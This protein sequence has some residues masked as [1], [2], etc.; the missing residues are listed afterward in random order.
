MKKNGH[1][2]GGF[3]LVEIMIVV[4]IIGLLCAIALPSFVRARATSQQNAC[5]NNL[6][7]IDSAVEQWAMETGQAAGNPPPGLT[8]DLTP[9]IQLNSNHA[10]PT[11][12]A[13]GTYTIYNVSNVP[14]VSCSL[15]TLTASPHILQ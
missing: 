10:I 8:T 12:P 3:T 6:R 2:C 13:G 4:A 7:Q 5:I 14:Q 11:C 15:S 9:Y 1:H